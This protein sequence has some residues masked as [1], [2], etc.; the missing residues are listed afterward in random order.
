MNC[1]NKSDLVLA[2]G[3]RLNPFGT[4]PQYGFDYWPKNAKLIQVEVDKSKI[5]WTKKVDLGIAACA[6]S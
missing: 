1:I 6:K 4:N 2:I 3:T 5:G